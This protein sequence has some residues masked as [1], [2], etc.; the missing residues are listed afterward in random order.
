MAT[1]YS[2]N[3]GPLRTSVRSRKPGRVH[4][5]L[6]AVLAF[7]EP[8]EQAGC[9][10]H[11][12]RPVEHTDELPFDEKVSHGVEI[13]VRFERD[14]AHRLSREEPHQPSESEYLQQTG[15]RPSHGHVATAF[16]QCPAE[17]KR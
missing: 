10:L 3:Q 12:M 1:H 13:A 16:G 6:P 7:P 8:T 5:D 14:D 17:R 15:N 4:D 9:V 2:N 11:R